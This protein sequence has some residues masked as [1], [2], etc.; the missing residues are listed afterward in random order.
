[1]SSSDTTMDNKLSDLLQVLERWRVW[2]DISAL[3]NHKAI[4][5]H[6][7]ACLDPV[8]EML[9]T[10]DYD[11]D[12]RVHYIIFNNDPLRDNSDDSGPRPQY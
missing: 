2:D 8:I 1:M 9:R 6:L 10:Q 7:R 3:A 4:K 5:D 12:V 11:L